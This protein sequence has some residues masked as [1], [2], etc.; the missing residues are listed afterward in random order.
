MIPAIR[1]GIVCLVLFLTSAVHTEAQPSV[2]ARLEQMLPKKGA[3]EY[4]PLNIRLTAQYDQEVLYGKSRS[5]FEP[6]VRREMVIDHLKTFSQNEQTELL[7][8]LESMRQAGKVKDIRS[9]WI[10]NFVHCKAHPDV[11]QELMTWK[12][13]AR[14]DLDRWQTIVQEA[15]P[16]A[17]HMNKGLA[18]EPNDSIS[19]SVSHIGAPMAWRKNYARFT[20]KGVV[21]A[22]LDSGINYEHQDIKDNM[23]LHDDYPGH[24]YNFV[25][26]NHNTFDNN[27]HGTHCAGIVA[28]NGA[29]GIYT[30][31]APEATIMNLKIV[32]GSSE[33]S[34][35]TVWE[36][37]EFAVEMGADVLS[38]SLGW[39]HVWN[40]DRV[41]WRLVLNNALN[42]GVIAAAATGNEGNV[43]G[44][45]PPNEVRTPGDIPPPWLHPDQ[46]SRGG[47][48]AVVSVGSSDQSDSISV[49]SGRGPVTWQDESPFNDYP[50][51]PGMGLIR[52]D[53]VSPGSGIL[54]LFFRNNTGYTLM[55]GTSQATPAVAGVM[56]LMLSKN[57]E[58]GP[59]KISRLLEESAY[60]LSASK[61]N[62]FGSGRLDAL[63]AV[64]Q[65]PY[66]GPRMVNHQLFE[67]DGNHDGNIHPGET[68]SMDIGLDNPSA[69]EL[70]NIHLVLRTSSP[71]ITILDSIAESVF[72]GVDEGIVVNEAF[73][74]KAAGDLPGDRPIEFLIKAWEAE[75]PDRVWTY[76]FS[77]KAHAPHLEFTDVFIEGSQSTGNIADI[78]PGERARATLFITN[79]GYYKS[80]TVDIRLRSLTDWITVLHHGGIQLG[81]VEP[82][83]TVSLSFPIEAFHTTPLQTAAGLSFTATTAAYIFDSYTEITIGE[84]PVYAGG[85]IPTTFKKEITT[86]SNAVEPGRMSVS[87]PEGASITG[88]DVEYTMSS[89]GGAWRIDQRSFLRCVSPG[90]ITEPEVFSGQGGS[91]GTFSYQRAGL[92]I[93][94]GVQGG[95]EVLF[96]LHAFRVW[97]EGDSGVDYVFVD[98]ESWRLVVHYELPEYEVVFQV[99]NQFGEGI[100]GAFF[101]AGNRFIETGPEGQFMLSVPEGPLYV[102]VT[103]ENHRPLIL[104]TLMVTPADSLFTIELIRVYRAE[105]MIYDP[106]GNQLNDA[107]VV[108]DGDTLAQ[109]KFVAGNLRDGQYRLVVLA[110]GFNP[111]ES[112]FSVVRSDLAITVVLDPLG[113]S[114][115]DPSPPAVLIYPNPALD[116][117]YVDLELNDAEALDIRIFNA[118]GILVKT[119]SIGGGGGKKTVVL[120]LSGF[121]AGIYLLEISGREWVISRKFIVR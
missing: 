64:R 60:P 33:S 113:T 16:H 99:N 110:E 44:V 14:L 67:V 4:I 19:W 37:I 71:Y 78:M 119:H 118:S 63:E 90:G 121:A 96:E 89:T 112:T 54:S 12:N 45:Q 23:W 65:T 29:S 46:T 27:G 30:G 102:S 91:G 108:I 73:T 34:E 74:F 48:S 66:P 9:F 70:G 35:A 109:G 93:A 47:I 25:D 55:G 3:E 32:G 69:R 62:T 61:N 43:Q 50:Y 75:R 38:M 11:V 6:G 95:G 98:N 40:P 5:V 94:N 101:E 80:D 114:I 7:A 68:L 22:I 15:R 51:D 79:S 92:D 31:V 56:A 84:A 116:L 77:E 111:H 53:L 58:T 72:P 105:F 20:G 87:I 85:N 83:D 86:G 26:R 10:A 13:L 17:G 107:V 100:E 81:P 52:P 117:L 1:K 106:E 28:G 57:P 42:A 21:V 115:A 82:G 39:S 103:A 2:S 59:E 120:E 41:M 76:Y 49:F 88:V 24:G 8:Y 97:G 18:D 104:D 36:A